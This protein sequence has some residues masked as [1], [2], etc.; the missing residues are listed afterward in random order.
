MRASPITQYLRKLTTSSGTLGRRTLI[1][2][3]QPSQLLVKARIVLLE[4]VIRCVV[5]AAQGVRAVEDLVFPCVVVDDIQN[6]FQ[7]GGMQVLYDGFESPHRF[8]RS[9]N[10][11]L[12][13]MSPARRR[14]A[15]INQKK[16]PQIR[17]VVVNGVMVNRHQLNGRNSQIQQVADCRL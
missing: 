17:E 11:T 4:P 15:L 9:L 10:Y 12:R 14:S 1:A 3:P 13:R 16:K 6:Y 8:Q 5:H 7:A 2:F